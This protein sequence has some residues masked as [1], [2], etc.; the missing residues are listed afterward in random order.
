MNAIKS[1]FSLLFVIRK[2]RLLKNGEAPVYL[3]ITVNSKV[4]DINVKRSAV[5]KCGISDES[6]VSGNCMLIGN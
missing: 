1:T 5:S 2:H 6:V 4:A 3:R